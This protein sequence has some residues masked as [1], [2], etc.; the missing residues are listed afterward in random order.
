M[1]LVGHYVVSVVLCSHNFIQI[2]RTERTLICTY[3]WAY[4]Q[5]LGLRTNV[6]NN[7]ICAA[8]VGS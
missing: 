3:Q 4:Y 1:E 6:S 8:Q 5:C 2:N 7:R